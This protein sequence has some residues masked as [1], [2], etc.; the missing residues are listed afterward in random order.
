M[1]CAHQRTGNRQGPRPETAADP[2]GRT[3]RRIAADDCTRCRTGCAPAGD[4]QSTRRAGR[5][6]SAGPC[7]E[8][9]QPPGVAADTCQQPAGHGEFCLGHRL[10]QGCRRRRPEKGPGRCRDQCHSRLPAGPAG[11]CAA[12]G[13]A[14]P[15]VGPAI[16]GVCPPARHPGRRRG[17][18]QPPAGDPGA[19]AVWLHV[20]RRRPWPGPAGR[21]PAA[22]QT[23]ARNGHPDRQRPRRHPV[24]LCL[25]QRLRS[26]G[27]DTRALAAPVRE[28]PAGAAGTAGW[29]NRGAAAWLAAQRRGVLVAWQDCAMAANRGGRHRPVPQPPREQSP[30]RK[31]WSSARWP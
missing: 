8:Q 13:D 21:R 4:P 16:R 5:D 31:A 3:Q 18:S 27:P 19:A 25:W 28:S 29:R 11:H 22:A 10:E 17:R 1:Q 30:P 23:L 26:R 20:R 14:Q 7:P 12:H 6:P 9:H 15:V 24:R 2:A